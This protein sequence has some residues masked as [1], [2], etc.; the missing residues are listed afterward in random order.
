MFQKT[1]VGSPRKN[2]PLLFRGRGICSCKSVSRV[3]YHVGVSLM[4]SIINL[5]LPLLT[6]SINLPI[7]TIIPINRND[8]GASRSAFR[9]Y[10]VFQLLRFTAIPV[11]RDC[12]E[13]LPH[14]FTLTPIRLERFIFCDTCCRRLPAPSC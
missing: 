13:L 9:T 1:L 12:R 14:V 7:L 6:G 4:T 10:L 5:D 8:T 2:N 11:A 3:L